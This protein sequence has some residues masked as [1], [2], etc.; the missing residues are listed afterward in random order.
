V[1]RST[2]IAEFAPTLFRSLR[3][4]K[5]TPESGLEMLDRS[6]AA[7][8]RT[9]YPVPGSD[10]DRH[11]REHPTDPICVIAGTGGFVS[12]RARLLAR[13]LVLVFLLHDAGMITERQTRAILDVTYHSLTPSSFATDLTIAAGG[14]IVDSL[15]LDPKVRGEMLASMATNRAGYVD[16]EGPW[17]EECLGKKLPPPQCRFM[18]AFPVAVELVAQLVTRDVWSR[19]AAFEALGTLCVQMSGD[20]WRGTPS[21][22]PH[23][24]TS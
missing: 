7:V 5:W 17:A 18:R 11:C 22:I 13:D 21:G 6:F 3:G 4:K 16:P 14:I 19:D 2:P 1:A 23:P 10:L 8:S 9:A 15:V 12:D 20:G 24:S